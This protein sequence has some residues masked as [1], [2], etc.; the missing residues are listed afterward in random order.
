MVLQFHGE[1][2]LCIS[3]SQKL[4]HFSEKRFTS[5]KRCTSIIVVVDLTDTVLII[6]WSISDEY[7]TERERG[8]GKK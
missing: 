1:L 8:D 3:G 4:E 6:L 2:I 5:I 7:E